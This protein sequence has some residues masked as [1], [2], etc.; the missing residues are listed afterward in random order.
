MITGL[1]LWVSGGEVVVVV[2]ANRLWVKVV[3]VEMDR[4]DGQ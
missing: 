4:G 2:L 1:P 3:E